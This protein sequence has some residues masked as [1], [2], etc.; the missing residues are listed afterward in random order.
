MTNK[1]HMSG[2]TRVRYSIGITEY[3]AKRSYSVTFKHL[4]IHTLADIVFDLLLGEFKM[5][6][7]NAS[8]FY[9]VFMIGFIP[10]AH[11]CITKRETVYESED[12]N[13]SSPPAYSML[14]VIVTSP[15]ERRSVISSAF[16]SDM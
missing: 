7:G 5:I 8:I 14:M 10:F 2:Q 3:L 16:L 1:L 13:K 15:L 4:D 9:P 6:I 12:L 11:H